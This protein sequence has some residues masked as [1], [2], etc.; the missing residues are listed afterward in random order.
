[1]ATG[2]LSG[3]AAGGALTVG[4]EVDA[5]AL[6]EAAGL[7]G[8]LAEPSGAAGVDERAGLDEA[9]PAAADDDLAP[10]AAPTC[11]TGATLA[12]KTAPGQCASQPA[13]ASAA[14]TPATAETIV[15]VRRLVAW[16][17]PCEPPR[18]DRNLSPGGL[19][20]GPGGPGG[21][22]SAGLGAVADGGCSGA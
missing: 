9:E 5:G 19:A 14:T 2:P 20:G 22:G 16:R 13:R 8:V 10:V 18:R 4:A 1:M 12:P 3:G 21:P 6:G 17:S 11:A 15:T 7:A